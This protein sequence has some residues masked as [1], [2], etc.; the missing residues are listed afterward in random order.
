[1]GLGG[2]RHALAALTPGKT[3]QGA[4]I[5]FRAVLDR[6]GKSRL[7][8]DSIPGPSNQ[9]TILT[10]LS[11]PTTK[12]VTHTKLRFWTQ[13]SSRLYPEIYF[14][15][16][17]YP[18]T[19]QNV[20]LKFFPPPWFVISCYPSRIPCLANILFLLTTC[21]STGF[22]NPG[23]GRRGLRPQWASSD[24]SD[25]LFF[26]YLSFSILPLLL[27]S[28]LDILFARAGRCVN[29]SPQ[30]HWTMRKAAEDTLQH[31]CACLYLDPL[32]LIS[33]SDRDK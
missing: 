2:Q 21:P 4:G 8:R 15:V 7:H 18:W 5:G 10:E 11:Q 28:Y 26:T 31:P 23:K 20:P 32:L 1:M 17:I 13:I 24:V 9:V 19:S 12:F 25:S 14:Y 27:P 33:R 29:A 22:R 30:I 3:R 6:R 16:I